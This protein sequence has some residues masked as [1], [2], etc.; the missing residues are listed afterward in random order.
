M[1][2]LVT[3][4]SLLL[5]TFKEVTL[6]TFQ[7][8]MKPHFIF[9]TSGHGR[10][11]EPPSRASMWRMGF[12]TPK[13]FD[14]DQTYCGWGFTHVIHSTPTHYALTHSVANSRRLGEIFETFQKLSKLVSWM[15]LWGDQN[16]HQQYLLLWF[17]KLNVV[18]TSDKQDL[19]VK[20]P[21]SS[22]LHAA[23]QFSIATPR[24]FT[25]WEENSRSVSVSAN[26]LFHK[27]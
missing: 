14:D 7:I 13:N 26:T 15:S 20:P 1:S 8:I 3:P 19:Y 10:L 9:Q 25:L 11:L 18:T 12:N 5:F 23:R 22:A 16:L 17:V 27:I 6:F 4:L 24:L 21:Y 2:L